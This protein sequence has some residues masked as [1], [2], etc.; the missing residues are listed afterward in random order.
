M[1]KIGQLELEMKTKDTMV[2]GF[3]ITPGHCMSCKQPLN[4]NLTTF[5]N[6]DINF[7]SSVNSTNKQNTNNSENISQIRAQTEADNKYNRNANLPKLNLSKQGKGFSK[8]I[9][10]WNQINND[11][12]KFKNPSLFMNKLETHQKYA[13]IEELKSLTDK[14]KRVKTV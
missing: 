9:S 13:E 14:S 12:G 7:F 6:T 10:K 8:T 1:V 5:L 2:S 11:D 3:A 4:D